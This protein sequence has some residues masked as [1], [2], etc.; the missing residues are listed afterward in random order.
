MLY[1][2][3]SALRGSGGGYVPENEH[4]STVERQA[5]YGAP[6]PVP[7]LA[8]AALRGRWQSV[9]VKDGVTYY[10]WRPVEPAIR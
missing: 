8:E 4:L 3:N 5:L 6:R 1:E 10:G 9:W 7:T 2:L